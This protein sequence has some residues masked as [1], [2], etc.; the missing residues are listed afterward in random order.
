MKVSSTIADLVRR[1]WGEEGGRVGSY[2]AGD[3][4]NEEERRRI[5]TPSWP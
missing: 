4:G 2:L 3:Q 5:F 1:A